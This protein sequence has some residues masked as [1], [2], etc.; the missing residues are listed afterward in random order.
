[1]ITGLSE[2]RE[3]KLNLIGAIAQ[4]QTAVA[5]ILDSIADL[6]SYSEE[7]AGH[8]A[9][10]IGQMAKYQQAMAQL[11]TGIAFP[12]VYH[13]TPESPWMNKDLIPLIAGPFMRELEVAQ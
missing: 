6:S 9:V 5:R 1:M 8:L 4:S 12:P 10:H 2:E 3:A 13:G 7:T 11:L